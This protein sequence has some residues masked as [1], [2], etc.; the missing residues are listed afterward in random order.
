MQLLFNRLAELEVALGH[1]RCNAAVLKKRQYPVK[2]RGPLFGVARFCALRCRAALTSCRAASAS[3]E[4]IATRLLR[5]MLTSEFKK[6]SMLR[7]V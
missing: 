3:E 7:S 4:R 6:A 2:S 5:S 1:P